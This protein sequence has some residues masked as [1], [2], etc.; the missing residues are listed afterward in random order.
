MTGPEHY[1]ESE[2]LLKQVRTAQTRMARRP[3]P[4]SIAVTIAEAQ[5]HATLA[6][7]AATLAAAYMPE[8]A[9]TDAWTA[10]VGTTDEADKPT[11]LAALGDALRKEHYEVDAMPGSDGS[12]I[13]DGNDWP[14]PTMRAFYDAEAGAR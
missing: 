10:I 2:S 11:P 4:Q 12:C 5:V 1:R 3:D 9:D 14:C 8:S 7:T 13:A 6:Q